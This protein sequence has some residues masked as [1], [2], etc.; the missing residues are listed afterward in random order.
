MSQSIIQKAK[1]IYLNHVANYIFTNQPKGIVL[2]LKKNNGY[3]VFQEP[4]LL[5][6]EKFLPIELLKPKQRKKREQIQ[7]KAT[8]N[9]QK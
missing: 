8:L 5:P 9:Q 3:V 4:T 1:L 2:N 7:L 6:E